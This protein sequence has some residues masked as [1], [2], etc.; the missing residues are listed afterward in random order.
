LTQW[1]P[2]LDALHPVLECERVLSVLLGVLVLPYSG[3]VAHD[4]EGVVRE[5]AIV[6]CEVT[7]RDVEAVRRSPNLGNDVRPSPSRAT[8]RS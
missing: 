8:R 3:A 7:Q 2:V 5:L 4:T 6:S 1:R